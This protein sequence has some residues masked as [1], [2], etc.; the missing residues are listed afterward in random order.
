[1]ENASFAMQT[2]VRNNL[3]LFVANFLGALYAP[4]KPVYALFRTESYAAGDPKPVRISVLDFT[5]VNYYVVGRASSISD[6]TFTNVGSVSLNHAK[7]FYSKDKKSFHIQDNS[8]FGTLIVRNE[9][10]EVLP[11]KE[12]F[13]QIDEKLINVRSYVP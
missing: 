5:A 8:R 3:I 13:F 11:G 2:S 1:M 7:V 6:L 10:F 12:E 4:D 9:P